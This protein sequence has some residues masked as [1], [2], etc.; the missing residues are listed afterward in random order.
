MRDR[1]QWLEKAT[2]MSI[3]VEDGNSSPDLETG[4]GE[5][6]RRQFI[7]DS[8]ENLIGLRPYEESLAMIEGYAAPEDSALAV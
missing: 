3:D 5:Y 2:G 4:E 1:A 7:T 6:P 8:R